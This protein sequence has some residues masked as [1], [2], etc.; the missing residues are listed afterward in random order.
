MAV[1]R[2]FPFL[3]LANIHIFGNLEVPAS[4][5]PLVVVAILVGTNYGIFH[6]LDLPV[7]NNLNIFWKTD[8]AQRSKASPKGRLNFCFL[9]RIKEVCAQMVLQFDIIDLVIAHQEGHYQ[10]PIRLEDHGLDGLFCWHL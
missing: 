8:W 9:S 4:I 1:W 3:D 5:G 6:I 2:D 10:F 7:G